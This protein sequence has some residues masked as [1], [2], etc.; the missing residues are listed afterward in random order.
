MSPIPVVVRA[1]YVSGYS[2]RITFH[3]GTA[4][5][6]D[7]SSWLNGPIFEPLRE[8][9][10]FKK[11]MISGSTISWPNGADIA[12][13]TLYSYSELPRTRRAT[14]DKSSSKARAGTA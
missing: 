4:K 10:Y 8:V 11:F 2:L 6:V 13:E 9:Q 7:F 12:P 14:S 1:E 3:D 5:L